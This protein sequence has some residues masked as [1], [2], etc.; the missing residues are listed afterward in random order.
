MPPL[1]GLKLIRY[2]VCKMDPWGC[3]LQI[4]AIEVS[5][6]VWGVLLPGPQGEQ[7]P[8]M[9]KDTVCVWKREFLMFSS[10][11]LPQLVVKHTLCPGS[12]VLV[13]MVA[14][15]MLEAAG[16]YPLTDN[17]WSTLGASIGWLWPGKFMFKLSALTTVSG[18]IMNIGRP[19]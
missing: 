13:Y 8:S 15:T 1:T 3:R 9:L 19:P 10:H 7:I 11:N 17:M 4:L 12:K 16:I 5:D 18:Y 6:I 2:Q 14:R